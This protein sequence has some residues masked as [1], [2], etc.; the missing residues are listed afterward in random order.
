MR[1]EN[2]ELENPG[3]LPS[4]GTLMT[5]ASAFLPN[6]GAGFPRLG[7]APLDTAEDESMEA[8]AQ[9]AEMRYKSLVEQIPVV[10]FMVSF[11]LRKSE[12]YVSPYVEKLLG[13]TAKEWTEDPILWYQRLYTEDRRR[14]NAE[15]SRT[16]ALAEPFKGD[17]RF[18][19]KN[20]RIVWIHGEVTVVR[21]AAGRPSFLQG[22]GYEITEL[23]L[24]EEV[25][26]R[27]QEDL[28]QLVKART[29]E[30]MTVN[31]SLESEIALRERVEENMRQS[32]KDLADV[33]S[34][35]DEHAIVA[36]TDPKGKITYANDK[37]CAISKY[38]REE[39]MGQDHRLIN[40]GFHP[41]EFMRDLWAGI[42][43]GK[44]WKGEILN[45][46]KDGTLYWVDTTIVP[47]LGIDGKPAQYVAIRADITERKRAQ[48]RQNELMGELK[49]IN[50]QLNQFAYVV[51]HDLKAPLRAIS[52]LADWLITDYGDKVGEAGREQ[53]AMLLGRTK[54]MNSLVDDLLDMYNIRAG[55][56]ELHLK[57]CDLVTLCHEV[58]REQ[59]LLTGRPIHLDVPSFP[60]IMQADEDR[61]SQVIVNLV[62]N[63]LRYSTEDSGVQLYV[64]KHHEVGIIEVCD[65]GTGI[66][67]EEQAHI[68][69]PFYRSPKNVCTSSK[70]GLG[71][72]L[73]ISKDI[74]ERHDGRIWCRSRVGQGS[75]FIV[76]MPLKGY[77]SRGRP[78]AR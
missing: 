49:E 46:A 72:G 13:Y 35:L 60:V 66:P 16:I 3:E 45:R 14:W 8:R 28:D 27:S 18:L 19:A 41:R 15:F 43:Q 77:V 32:L 48:E 7:S 17:Y 55:K 26:R 50:E 64:D 73:A 38:S 37:F 6:L 9:K 51:S 1:L 2:V 23:K 24:A 30:I 29:V 75:T 33:K 59:R 36:I 68:F 76:E 62:G 22:I 12:I 52:S 58:V 34:A 74:V 57:P 44:V 67:Q 39:L 63:A 61:L 65:A 54:R 47:F 42:T 69:E 71:L 20:G 5:L 31:K 4:F 78:L 53:F 21:D 56:I 11:G 70:S 25:L 40:S 10:T